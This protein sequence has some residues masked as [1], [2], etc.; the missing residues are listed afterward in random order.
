MPHTITASLLR[1]HAT[2]TRHIWLHTHGDETQQSDL[3][4]GT[5]YSLEQGQQHEQNVH[6]AT[7]QEIRS[8]PADSWSDAVQ[9]TRELMQAGRGTILN[10]P[11][12][13]QFEVPNYT[14]PFIIRGKIDRLQK[15]SRRQHNLPY[16][17]SYFPIEIKHYHKI[18]IEDALQLDLYIWMLRETLQEPLNH[19][20]FWLSADV[21]HRPQKRILH[22][23][24]EERLMNHLHNVARLMHDTTNEPPVRLRPHC[25]RCHWKRACTQQA[26]GE[27]NVTLLRPREETLQDMMDANIHTLSDVIRTDEKT[28]ITLR[29]VGK[30]TARK[31]R[32]K[33]QAYL[34]DRPIL[35]QTPPKITQEEGWYFDIETHP[36]KPNWVWSIGWRWQTNESQ[37]ILVIPNSQPS[38]LTLP[39]GRLIQAVPDSHSAWELFHD[40]VICQYTTHLSL[41][42]V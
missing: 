39:D 38:T 16:P 28:L 31:M 37:V 41:D 40:N 32:A 36:S 17:I 5:I 10:A 8:I 4:A 25:D 22:E 3:S 24:N 15:L 2:C 34:E 23:Y 33:A 9:I 1:W 18:D 7:T 12:E 35:M 26:R 21:T 42:E 20:E 19:G 13:I 29:Q 27:Q 11:L 6:E 14:E 30:T